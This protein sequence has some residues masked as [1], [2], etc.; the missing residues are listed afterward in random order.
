M[1]YLACRISQ[2]VLCLPLRGANA[3]R[4]RYVMAR[5]QITCFLKSIT[6][7]WCIWSFIGSF[8]CFVFLPSLLVVVVVVFLKKNFLYIPGGQNMAWKSYVLFSWALT[9]LLST[10]KHFTPVLR[11]RYLYENKCNE[12]RVCQ[13][14][15]LWG[16]K[17]QSR[18]IRRYNCCT[19]SVGRSSVPE[20]NL[21][22]LISNSAEHPHPGIRAWACAFA[23]AKAARI[24][25]Y[26]MVLLLIKVLWSVEKKERFSFSVDFF[27]LFLKICDAVIFFFIISFGCFSPRFVPS[28]SFCLSVFLCISFFL[29][30]LLCFQLVFF[31]LNVRL[32]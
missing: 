21:W 26:L 4:V 24:S 10:N 13:A 1:S 29:V 14:C 28:V 8:F 9:S 7:Q 5:T 27:L 3:F 16:A 15:R 18:E 23:M 2:P 30:C 11:Y 31:F 22:A 25:G 6:N 20:V 17:D 12:A 19:S 32:A